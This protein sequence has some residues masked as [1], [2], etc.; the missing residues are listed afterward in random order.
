M[1][2]DCRIAFIIFLEF[3]C[4]GDAVSKVE[5]RVRVG[6]FLPVMIESKIS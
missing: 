5:F 1:H 4:D 3:K 2:R 6:K